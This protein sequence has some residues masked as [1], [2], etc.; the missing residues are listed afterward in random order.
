[1][2]CARTAPRC[3]RTHIY[4]L[5]ALHPRLFSTEKPSLPVPP[6]P[7]T[8]QHNDLRSF[9]DYAERTSLSTQ[10]TTYVGTLYEYTVQQSL[11]RHRID[12]TRIGGRADCGIDLVGTWSLPPLRSRS[13][14]TA[15]QPL[16][17]LVQCKALK[18]KVGPNLIRELEGTFSGAPVGW[19]GEGIL[20]MLVSTREATKGVRDA[21]V[22]SRYPLIWAL[23]E[24]D[25]SM[26][27]F[28]WNRRAAEVGL[29]GLG[30]QI[31]HGGETDPLKKTVVLTWNG[32]E[33]GPEVFEY[34][35]IQ[36]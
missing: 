15:A 7:P 4:G 14:S 36:S 13:T 35:L 29:E 20:G 12:L 22:K 2:L 17:I 1:M 33:I 16:R 8:S 6:A 19:R 18:T 31:R 26:R 27:Q 28:L 23:A 9:L 24:L 21:L 3:Y 32:E 11:K 30:V 5:K 34:G 10:S 25:G